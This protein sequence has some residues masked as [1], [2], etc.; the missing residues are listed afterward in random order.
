MN[1]FQNKGK[2]TLLQ[3]SS[4]TKIGIQFKDK[5]RLCVH[6]E[7]DF[8]LSG[9]IMNI[10]D[11]LPFSVRTRA[12][13]PSKIKQNLNIYCMYLLIPILEICI[14]QVYVSEKS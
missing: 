7:V 8:F 9:E 6:R 2:I 12:L 1:K 4:Q 11:Y 3:E 13:C 10:T 14:G 5:K